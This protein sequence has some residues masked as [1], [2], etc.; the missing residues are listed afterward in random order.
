MKKFS[1]FTVPFSIERGFTLIEILTVISILAVIGTI[2]VGI[3]QLTLRSS[4]KVDLMESAR[5]NGDATLSQ[6]V[7]TIRYAASLDDPLSCVPST[8]VSSITVSAVTT[9]IQ[10]TYACSG[11]TIKTDGVSMFNTSTLNVNSCSFVCMQPTV[12]D[13]P[14]ITIQYT[15]TPATAGIFS[16]TKF[17][18]PFQSS[19]TMRNVQ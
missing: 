19:V 10:T 16:E 11:N 4:K 12:T 7:R 5:Q 6:M 15:L 9:H 18:L 1:F 13:P 8:T 14:T 17:S 2:A 3:I